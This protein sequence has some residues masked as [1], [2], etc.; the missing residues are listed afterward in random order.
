[1]ILCSIS[2]LQNVKMAF[3]LQQKSFKIFALGL[4]LKSQF[5]TARL[6][7]RLVFHRFIILCLKVEL[8]NECTPNS[9]LIL[10][11][12]QHQVHIDRLIIQTTLSEKDDN[13]FY[14]TQILQHRKSAKTVYRKMTQD[15]C[16]SLGR[17]V[18]SG[19]GTTC[20]TY[21]VY[22]KLSNS[23]SMHNFGCLF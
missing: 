3:R 18:K 23:W 14:Y 12:F 11:C 20:L 10:F 6:F 2:F 19:L 4:P 5:L 17:L 22:L 15:D 13:T 16:L 9:F 1:M 7:S 21:L 8:M